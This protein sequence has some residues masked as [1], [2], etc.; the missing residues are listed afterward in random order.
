MTIC[1]FTASGN[2]L[3]VARRIGGTLR[4]IPQLMRQDKIEIEDDAV[5]IVCPVYAVELP[6]MI[7]DFMKRA[8]IKTDY[9][10]FILTCGYGYEV[11][12]GHAEVAAR[13]R[14]WDLKYGSGVLMVD[15]Y[16]PFFDMDEERRKIAAVFISR[17]ISVSVFPAW[18]RASSVRQSVRGL[19]CR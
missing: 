16:L 7:V 3:Y 14:G 8:D 11:S 2:C 13:E 6:F 19:C 17:G 12:L 9:F 5:G 1:Y 10:F 18:I 4:S 15:N